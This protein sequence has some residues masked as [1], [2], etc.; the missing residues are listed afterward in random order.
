M[1]IKKV[2]SAQIDGVGVAGKVSELESCVYEFSID[3]LTDE[4]V[5]EAAVCLGELLKAKVAIA[6]NVTLVVEGCDELVL[7]VLTLDD[8]LKVLLSN[9]ST[10]FGGE[11]A[12][13][14]NA[15][16]RC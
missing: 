14:V 12:A 3:L 8:V 15:E 6:I 9:D 10:F 7:I 2:N 1:A 13:D 5:D 16:C 11:E 4:E